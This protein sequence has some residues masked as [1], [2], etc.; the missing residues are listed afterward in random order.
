MQKT[1]LALPDAFIKDT[2][3]IR[4]FKFLCC[5]VN[6]HYFPLKNRYFDNEF[7]EYCK[8]S[9]I[10]SGI[11]DE[12]VDTDLII[13]YLKQLIII[14]KHSNILQNYRGIARVKMETVSY[15]SI[16]LM[17]FYSFWNNVQWEEIFPSLP[18]AAKALKKNR[19]LMIELMINQTDIFRIDCL[20]NEFFVN[21]SFTGVRDIYLISFLDF[22]FFTWLKFFGITRY[23]VGSSDEP[24]K[25][26]LTEYG[27][28]FL[29]Y[30]QQRPY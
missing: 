2:F 7:Y 4:L 6:D 17:L 18:N 1:N 26:E 25:V 21:I 27:R 11:A 24:V 30:V 14:M 15:N 22:Y 16:F 28:I 10:D 20:T 8:E 9:L 3:V 5:F 29:Q 13:I 12:I 19:Q 23:L